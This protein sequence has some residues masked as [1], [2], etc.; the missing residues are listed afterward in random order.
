[1]PEMGVVEIDIAYADLLSHA[2]GRRSESRATVARR[3]ATIDL[4]VRRV[5]PGKTALGGA[6]VGA[7]A[8]NESPV[9]RTSAETPPAGTDSGGIKENGDDGS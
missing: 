2:E 8:V 1:M 9:G 6:L 5:L 3:G 7:S 4:P